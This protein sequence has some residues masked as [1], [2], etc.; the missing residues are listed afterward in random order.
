M[1]DSA[2]HRNESR[3]AHYRLDF[4]AQDAHAVHMDCHLHDGQ[5]QIT[6]P[7]REEASA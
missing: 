5:L 6:S 1:T 4:P 2:A 7:C 3:G